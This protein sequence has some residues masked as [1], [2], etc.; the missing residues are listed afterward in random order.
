LTELEP[1][2][3]IE[4]NAGNPAMWFEEAVV[5]PLWPDLKL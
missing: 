3:M 4:W 1:P 5:G 2:R